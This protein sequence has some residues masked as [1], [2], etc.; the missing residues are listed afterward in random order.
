[1]AMLEGKLAEGSEVTVDAI[2]GEIVVR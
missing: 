2:D 1:M